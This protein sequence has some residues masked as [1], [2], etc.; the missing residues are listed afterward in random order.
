MRIVGKEV[1]MKKSNEPE[2]KGTILGKRI[3][4]YISRS[5]EYLRRIEAWFAG[6]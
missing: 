5:S 2:E 3:P 6:R 1:G 4:R